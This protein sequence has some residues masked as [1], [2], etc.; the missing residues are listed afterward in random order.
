MKRK[1]INLDVERLNR[2]NLNIK[3]MNKALLKVEDE[4]ESVLIERKAIIK[5]LKIMNAEAKKLLKRMNK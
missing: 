5:A 1:N 2:I 4:I 3:A